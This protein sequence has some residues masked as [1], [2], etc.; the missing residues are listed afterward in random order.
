MILLKIPDE[1]KTTDIQVRFIE[2]VILIACITIY[3]ILN[4]NN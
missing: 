1:M 2:I 4:R 3:Y